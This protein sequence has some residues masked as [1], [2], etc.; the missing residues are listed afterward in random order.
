MPCSFLR[1][2]HVDCR[3]PLSLPDEP[4]FVVLP[5]VSLTNHLQQDYFSECRTRLSAARVPL[6][7]HDDVRVVV[8]R[9]PNERFSDRCSP[10]EPKQ[11]NEALPICRRREDKRGE[12]FAARKG[13]GFTRVDREFKKRV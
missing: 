8:G 4:S 9:L 5:F 11:F 10:I 6:T 3:K 12:Q 7:Q 13:V 1:V 2:R